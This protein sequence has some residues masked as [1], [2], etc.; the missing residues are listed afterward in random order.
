MIN[1]LAAFLKAHNSETPNTRNWKLFSKKSGDIFKMQR[2]VTKEEKL[3]F[4]E[5][6]ESIKKQLMAIASKEN[7]AILEIPFLAS[8][9]CQY[10][11]S[12]QEVLGRY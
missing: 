8:N 3:I 4:Y 7:S 5:V 6:L 1:D 2:A 12:S 9:S 11:I 10:R